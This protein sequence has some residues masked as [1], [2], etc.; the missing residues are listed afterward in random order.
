MTAPLRQFRFLDENDNVI[1]EPHIGAQTDALEYGVNDLLFC[2]TRGPGK[3]DAQLMRFRSLVGMGYGTFWRGIIF[4]KE[5]KMLD[6]LVTKSKRWFF[7]MNDGARFL[8]S[9]SDYKWIWPTG[10]ELLFRQVSRLD[11]YWS[12]HGHEYPFVGWNELTKYAT[13]ELYERMMSVNRSGFDPGKNTPRLEGD[14]WVAEWNRICQAGHYEGRPFRSGD[15][16]TIDGRPLPPIPLEVFSTCNP[17]GPG[18]NWVKRRFVDI[19]T[20]GKIVY[21]RT[22]VLDPKTQ[23]EIEVVRTQSTIFGKHSENRNLD[24]VYLAGLK[25]TSNDNERKAWDD[26][27]WDIVAGGAFDDVYTKST[28]VL[29]RFKVPKGWFVDRSMDWGSSH[30]FSIGW[31]SEANGE[32]A[33]LPDGRIFC[34][35][36]GTL[37]QIAEIYGTK[38]IGTNKGLKLGAKEVARLIKE[39][40]AELVNGGW[41]SGKI[42][43]GPADNQISDVHEASSDTIEKIMSDNKVTWERSDKSP[44][45]RKVGMQLMRDRFE[46]LTNHEGPGLAFMANCVGSIA[47]I[48]V[49]PRD[50]DKIDDVDTSAE[51]HPYDMTR[52]RVL[53]GNRRTATVIKVNFPR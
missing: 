45:S 2:G 14:N 17:L 31:W 28:H 52:Y 10:E 22:V 42:Y 48:P 47:T 39:K 49:L 19:A 5:Y 15:Y 30:P 38:E 32:E 1:W 27:D 25:N 50:K 12:Y 7:P 41:V 40:E 44:G 36:P 24:P 8:S 20:Y 4:D 16:E 35:P 51:D 9:N 29:P 11:D 46:N 34:P 6:D 13:A 21:K 33:I 53:K 18:H 43:E 23:T 26:G 3:T 37:I